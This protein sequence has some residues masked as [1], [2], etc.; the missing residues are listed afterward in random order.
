MTPEDWNYLA[1]TGNVTTIRLPIGYFTLGPRFCQGTPFERYS[2]VYENAW[3]YVKQYISTAASYG[4]ATLIDL[5]ALPGGANKDAHSGTTSHKAEL[6]GNSRN[7]S[8]SVECLK[9]IAMET[10]DM[11]FVS[12][13]QLAN[14]AVYQA[15]GMYNFYDNVINAIYLINPHVPLYIS[16][17]WEVRPALQYSKNVNE[18]WLNPIVVDTHKY[19]TFDE[20]HKRLN[21]YQ[22]IEAVNLNEVVEVKD[23]GAGC[24]IGEY[25]CV[26]DGRSWGN[27]QGEE[28]KR[29][30]TQFGQRQTETWRRSSGGC[31]FWTYKMVSN[32]L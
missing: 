30:A 28:R 24:I 15:S 29:L 12:G 4:I 32:L 11:P 10:R 5:H 13:I 17:G 23:Q 14:E 1:N 22:I 21:P 27:I 25:S 16:D 8:L 2:K 9:F 6:W 19:Y 7:L 31:F 20:E 18:R 3:L 26:M